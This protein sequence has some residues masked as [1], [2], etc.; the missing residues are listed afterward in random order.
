MKSKVLKLMFTILFIIGMISIMTITE[1]KTV[2]DINGDECVT[3]TDVA[4]LKQHLTDTKI[5][6][7]A[8]Q[9]YADINR[10]NVV[11]NTDLLAIKNII[12]GKYEGSL[13]LID[14][15]DS[16][17][18]AEAE[19][20]EDNDDD[21]VTVKYVTDPKDYPDNL[22]DRLDSIKKS[23][24]QCDGSVYTDI[25]NKEQ[26]LARGDKYNITSDPLVYRAVKVIG[27][28][29]TEIPGNE[30]MGSRI[31]NVSA[32]M[33]GSFTN[34]W[35]KV[36]SDNKV[37]ETEIEAGAETT[38]DEDVT[39]YA[40]YEFKVDSNASIASGSLSNE[41][42]LIYFYPEEEMEINVKFGLEDRLTVSYPQY[43]PGEGWNILARPD[44]MITDLK[45]RKNYRYLLYESVV[46][47]DKN[48]DGFVVKREDTAEFLEEKL[49][50]LG[51]NE[52][53]SADFITYWLPLLEA[54][55]YN[56]IRFAESKYIEEN[57]PLEITPKPDS[58]IRVYMEYLGLDE[59][60]EIKEQKLVSP[61]RF[62][63]TV[64]EW[65]GKAI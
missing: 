10:D 11:S 25:Q 9:I 19:E 42:P 49:A 8:R 57:M 17:E 34:K 47:K 18:E 13:V 50:I 63:Y 37:D 39:L 31:V 7:E 5:I 46:E 41:L 14:D 30:H 24:K 58:I 53:E 61:A 3:T 32:T 54:N 64:V 44:G 56:F 35:I 55:N 2:G 45:T 16:E 6:D 51:L 27:S 62:G 22:D 26:K 48:T 36:T 65:G 20:I 59:K 15:N 1:A 33:T 40:V 21:M 4:Q 60:I 12:L 28:S 38:A 52:K 29:T 43:Q 23:N